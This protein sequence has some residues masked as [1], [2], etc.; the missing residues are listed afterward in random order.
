MATLKKTVDENGI[1]V[2]SV[3]SEKRTVEKAFVLSRRT[4]WPTDE[5][6]KPVE[7][8]FRVVID[9]EGISFKEILDDAIRNK[10]ITLQQALRG[11]TKKP[12]PFELLKS[13]SKE[14]LRRRYND[15]GAGIENPEKQKQ[16]VENAFAALDAEGQ[17]ALLKK[18]QAQVNLKKE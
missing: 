1:T 14:T 13:M 6:G 4:D 8:S 16:T 5:E 17:K 3:L 2:G 9:L 7:L 12:V 15:C 18:L 11:T 10:V